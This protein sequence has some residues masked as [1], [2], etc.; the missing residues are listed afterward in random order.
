MREDKLLDPKTLINFS[1]LSHGGQSPQIMNTA[2]VLQTNVKTIVTENQSPDIKSIKI[3]DDS[4]K[5]SEHIQFKDE[6]KN[7]KKKKKE[8]I[9]SPPIEENQ[10]KLT[11][12]VNN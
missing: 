4:N 2:N 1:K 12:M 7:Q 3:S 11:E 8:K 6:N 9:K 10:G 5:A